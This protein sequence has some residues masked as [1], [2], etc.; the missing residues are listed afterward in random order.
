MR[1]A[2]LVALAACGGSQ[3]STTTERPATDVTKLLPAT[4]EATQPKYGDPRSVHVRVWADAGVRAMPHWKDDIADEID[5]A[6]Q[7]LTPLVGV[8]LVVDATKDW[9]RKG[10]D[11]H[12]A[13]KQLA[14]V[15]DGNDVTWA[16]GSGDVPDNSVTSPTA[17]R[18]PSFRSLAAATT[19]WPGWPLRR[20]LMLRLVV[21]ARPTGP[22]RDSSTTYMAKSASAISVGPDTVPPGRSM[23]SL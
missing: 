1:R 18:L 17:R 8:K 20:K 5:Y 14:T 2:L 19:S 22:I 7:L 13:A 10:V 6:N 23:R 21:T 12:D 3:V 9:D 11:F 15:D 4:L 16:I